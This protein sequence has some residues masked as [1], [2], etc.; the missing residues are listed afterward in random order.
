MI[1]LD[2]GLRRRV[3]AILQTEASE[4]ALACIAMVANHFGYRTTLGE[5]RKE[6]PISLKG[7]TLEDVASICER[8]GLVVR[9]LR[10]E[11]SELAQLPVPAILHWNLNHFVVLTGVRGDKVRINDPAHGELELPISEVSTRFTGVALELTPGFEFRRK[12]PPPPLRLR[13]IVGRVSGL[14]S[15]LLQVFCLALVLE[16]LAIG[17][18]LLTQWITDEVIV[19]GSHD[20]LTTLGLAA[21]VV[22]VVIAGISA[23]RAWVSLYIGAHFNLQWVANV[24]THLLRLPVDFFERRHVGDV[25]SR[26]ASASTIAHTLTGTTVE[27]ALDGLLALGMLLM[28]M[29]YSPWLSGLVVGAVGLYVIVRWARLSAVRLAA[30]G[31]LAKHA[32]EQTFFLETIRGVRSIKLFNREAE[33]RSAWLT[34]WVEATNA[35]LVIE[36]F[37]LLFGGLWGV[38]SAVERAGILWLGA[39]AVTNH[40]MSLGMLLA[41][42]TYKEQ[43]TSRVGSFVDRI[44]EIK[45]LSV[46]TERLADIVLGEVEEKARPAIKDGLGELSLAL[47]K[48]T[49]RYAPGER[50]I[51]SNAS[52]VIRPGECIAIVGASGAGKTTCLKVLLGILKPTQGQVKLA[53]RPLNHIGLRAYRDLTAAV[54]QDDHLFAGSIFDNICFHDAK[55]EEDWTR[56]CARDAGIDDEIVA[57]PMGYHTLVGDMGTVLSGGQKQRIMLARAL[58][59]RPRILFLDEATSHLDLDNE[60][61]ISETLATLEMTRVVIAHR[62]Q[63][64]AIADRVLR[65]HE[66]R[67]IEDKSHTAAGKADSRPHLVASSGAA[68][69]ASQG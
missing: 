38:L 30:S 60:R 68:A 59:R 36:R 9:G 42:F 24:M 19:A 25:V 46:S 34:L 50:P 58:Y 39:L 66:G 43:F 22:G 31:A 67:F 1:Q 51:L 49:F 27:I 2:L 62:P 7:A 10:L 13:Q 18:P 12:A 33:R 35:A 5:L 3:H 64:I 65:L 15:S 57:M 63:T 48:V 28:M 54:M 14:R 32:K 56:Q 4:C 23:L 52:L 8:L 11:L 40:R 47:D 55:P 53:G 41:F 45:M 16:G 29:L 37:N 20:L 6:H 17:L 61:R 69:A 44:I 21:M 26:F